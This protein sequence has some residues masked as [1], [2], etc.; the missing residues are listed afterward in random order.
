MGREDRERRDW[1][2]KTGRGTSNTKLAAVGV[3]HKD[4]D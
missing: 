3:T 4:R 2:E 1:G